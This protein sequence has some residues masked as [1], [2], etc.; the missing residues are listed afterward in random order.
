MNRWFYWQTRWFHWQARQ[1]SRRRFLKQVLGVTFGTLSALAVGRL[2][3][4]AD[5][6]GRCNG[7]V[8]CVAPFGGGACPSAN[9]YHG[10][11][12]QNAGQ[13][14]CQYTSCCCPSGGNCWT[15]LG[16][17]QNNQPY[18]YTCCDC[19]CGTLGTNFYCLCGPA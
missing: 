4:L 3:P 7:D 5:C 13:V 1:T 8:P 17:D 9:C 10:W 6:G 18:C 2:N 11:G 15:Y 14:T 12:C 16:T 19:Y